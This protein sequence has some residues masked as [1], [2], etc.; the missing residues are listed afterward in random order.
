MREVK[1]ANRRRSETVIVK[2]TPD[3]KALFVGA[4][5]GAMLDL[6]AWMRTVC[7]AAARRRLE[8]GAR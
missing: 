4:A 3:E 1:A 2:L 8:R 5:D 6:S 7:S